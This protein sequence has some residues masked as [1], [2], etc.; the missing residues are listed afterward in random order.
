MGLFGGR[1]KVSGEATYLQR[2]DDCEPVY[3]VGESKYQREISAITGR[4]GTQAIDH[5][6]IA[7]LVPNKEGRMTVQ[8][9]AKVVGF[10]SYDDEDHY[11]P[12]LG[13]AFSRGQVFA[14]DAQI[15]AHSGD[16]QTTNAGVKLW[17]PPPAVLAKA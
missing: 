4:Q 1:K 12:V 13:K 7:V 10:L 5:A 3:V 2:E 16:T 8:I 14:F 11:G 6:A 15:V 9:D 17:M